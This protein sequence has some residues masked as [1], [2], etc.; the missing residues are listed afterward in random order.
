MCVIYSLYLTPVFWAS[1][2][3]AYHCIC[4]HCITLIAAYC[5]FSS[6]SKGKAAFCERVE[7]FLGESKLKLDL[8]RAEKTVNYDFLRAILAMNILYMYYLAEC[9]CVCLCVC[10]APFSLSLAWRTAAAGAHHVSDNTLSDS[11]LT[12]LAH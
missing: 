2:C 8:M 3:I 1:R 7:S 6:I 11:G 10:T 9:L 4:I 5:L 12:E